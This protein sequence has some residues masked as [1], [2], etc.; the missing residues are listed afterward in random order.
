MK[1]QTLF[2][3]WSL[4]EAEAYK[5][6][7]DSALRKL[8]EIENPNT[9]AFKKK[10]KKKAGAN[11]DKQFADALIQYEAMIKLAHEREELIWNK[12]QEINR[13]MTATEK[14]LLRNPTETKEAW[15]KRLSGMTSRSIEKTGK[16]M[17]K[18]FKLV[19]AA[20]GEAEDEYATS[21]TNDGFKSNKEGYTDLERLIVVADES[22]FNSDTGVFAP[23]SYSNI[24]ACPTAPRDIKSAKKSLLLEPNN[25]NTHGRAM[26][27]V[28][29][30]S[31]F[32]NYRAQYIY[33]VADKLADI[34]EEN[35]KYSIVAELIST[36]LSDTK[37][38][39][40]DMSPWFEAQ[41]KMKSSPYIGFRET[42][43]A[44][45]KVKKQ[46]NKTKK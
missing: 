31:K 28:I 41:A 7:T 27:E 1:L 23:Y 40:L 14:K 16:A 44:L 45:S 42:V 9:E 39:T 35:S 17:D 10:L 25:M 8:W 6:P 36:F 3:T 11:F 38:K 24:T 2:E 5:K 37:Y 22:I 30:V 46:P 15:I 4:N 19:H 32:E 21:L 43:D 34:V 13:P 26:E 18:Y 12:E 20:F 33:G 29:T